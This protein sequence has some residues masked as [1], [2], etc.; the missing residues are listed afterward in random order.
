MLLDRFGYTLE[1]HRN[2]IFFRFPHIGEGFLEWVSSIPGAPRVRS[3]DPWSEV[4]AGEERR[5]GDVA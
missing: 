2:H 1:I 3:F 4:I 5:Q